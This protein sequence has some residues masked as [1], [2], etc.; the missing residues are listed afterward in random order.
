MKEAKEKSMT[1]PLAYAF[2]ATQS[3]PQKYDSINGMNDENE[4]PGLEKY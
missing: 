2:S 3:T 4:T 1:R